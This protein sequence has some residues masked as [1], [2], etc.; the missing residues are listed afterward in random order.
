MVRP[1][2]PALHYLSWT[3]ALSCA[4]S[5]ALADGALMA[6]RRTTALS[7]R[8]AKLL[9]AGT[10]PG[11]PNA[12]ATLA[13]ALTADPR[14]TM[15]RPSA[16]ALLGPLGPAATAQA[17]PFPDLLEVDAPSPLDAS[18][19]ADRLRHRPGVTV[20]LLAPAP[21]VPRTA[22]PAAWIAIGLALVHAGWAAHLHVRRRTS[23]WLLLQRIGA[24]PNRL[25]GEALAP[26][27][28]SGGLGAVVGAGLCTVLPFFGQDDAG[29]A[30][31]AI[32]AMLTLSAALLG[33][34]G[35]LRRMMAAL[36]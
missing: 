7:H 8:P 2:L 27:A 3:V 26:T 36:P 32:A 5:A 24:S 15:S 14:L 35:S 29:V 22:R 11:Q 18:L 1:L 10:D 28:L 17:L 33:A 23:L 16:E 4:C 13:D 21:E 19:L 34:L 9:I 6:E 31:M 30:W 12:V 20:R 25:L